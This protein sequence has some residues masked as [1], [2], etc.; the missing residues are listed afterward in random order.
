MSDETLDRLRQRVDASPRLKRVE[1][2]LQQELL[3]RMGSEGNTIGL[4]PITILMIISVI[5]QVVQ[6]CRTQNK[7]DNIA[8]AAD[9]CTAPVLPPRRTIRLRRK[10]NALWHDY[11]VKNNLTH[12]EFNPFLA[13]VYAISPTVDTDTAAEFVQA[14]EL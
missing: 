5:I 10:M 4:D 9:L 14:A 13:A 3:A 8:I 12:T 11:C 2:Q 6:Y 1:E 7:R